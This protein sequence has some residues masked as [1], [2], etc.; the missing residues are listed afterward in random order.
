MC[1]PVISY[2]PS[3]VNEKYE[4]I[5]TRLKIQCYIPM[6]VEENMD[7]DDEWIEQFQGAAF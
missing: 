1:P 7:A 4:Q 3:T 2:A 5:Q 6:I